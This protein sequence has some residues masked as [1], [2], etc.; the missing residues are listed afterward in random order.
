MAVPQGEGWTIRAERI[1]ARQDVDSECTYRLNPMIIEQKASS[2]KQ[3]IDM[4]EAMM[5]LIRELRT[6]VNELQQA[7]DDNIQHTVNKINEMDKETSDKLSVN[8]TDNLTANVTVS[9]L[10][11]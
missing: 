3:K 8:A 10:Y 7:N 4:D 1:G 9:V 5:E 2:T 11:K 6:D